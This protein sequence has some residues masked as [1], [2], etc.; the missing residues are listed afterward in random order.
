MNEVI[1]LIIGS[2]GATITLIA[3]VLNQTNRISN[4]NFYYDLANFA[5][6]VLL[7]I[8]AFILGSVPFMIINAVWGLVSLKDLVFREK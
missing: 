2:L 1:T 5:S 8:Y 4:D 6:G 7:F 3:F